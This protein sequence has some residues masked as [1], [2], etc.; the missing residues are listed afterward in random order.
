ME[1]KNQGRKKEA[2]QKEGRQK[3]RGTKNQ[4]RLKNQ[5]VLL[6]KITWSQVSKILLACSESMFLDTY[7]RQG[8]G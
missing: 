7:V 2:D 5:E 8:H 1:T 3:I 4:K 6:R